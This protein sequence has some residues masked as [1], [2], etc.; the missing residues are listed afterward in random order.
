MLADTVQRVTE[1]VP[2][3]NILVV[4]S[5][6]LR[7]PV[8][9][10]LSGLGRDQILCEP[11]GRN[12]APCVA[13]AA[14]EIA[15]R[16][17]D[18]AMLVLPADHVVAPLR[19]YLADMELGLSVAYFERRLVTF[20][21]PP[22]HPETGYGYLREGTALGNSW[23]RPRVKRV[24]AFHEKPTA[25]RARKFL[26]GGFYWNSGMFAWRADVI[27]EELAEHLPELAAAIEKLDGTRKGA[28]IPQRVLN[29]GYPKLQSISIDHG[30]M[31][32]SARVAMVIAGFR[33]NDIGSWDAVGELWPR[34]GAG[35]ASRDPLIAIDSRNNVVAS[36]T[37][38]VALLGVSDLAV[39]DAGD[40][41]LICPRER[42]QEVRS[43]VAALE[44]ANLG[45]LR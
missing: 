16:D 14:L 11:G 23:P 8:E 9:R 44:R 33:W 5:E 6:A 22:T 3:K 32:K 20:G 24:G 27:R 38:P 40:A 13:W 7:R 31:E 34:D 45:Q 4:T 18:A 36:R 41:L 28:R 12:T 2:R 19:K 30:V 25:A 1:I 15:R 10:E 37:K 29:A 42:A 35:N 26:A 21:I 43:V 39:V 17:P